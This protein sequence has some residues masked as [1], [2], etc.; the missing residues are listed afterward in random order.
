MRTLFE[1]GAHSFK[2]KIMCSKKTNYY[3]LRYIKKLHN[4]IKKPVP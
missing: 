1:S 4:I 3:N 2:K